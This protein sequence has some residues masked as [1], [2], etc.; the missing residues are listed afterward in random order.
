MLYAAV[1]LSAAWLSHFAM[2]SNDVFPLRW[3]ANQL[4][5]HHPETFYDG[6]FPIGYPLLLR[7]AGLTG[8]PVLAT[9]I[10]QIALAAIYARLAWGVLRATLSEEAAIIAL[11]F[12]LFLPQI[13]GNIL[14]VTPDFLAALSAIA[15]FCFLIPTNTRRNIF[16]AGICLG[17]GYLF[18][19][20]LIVLV[21]SLTLALLI[22]EKKR[23]FRAILWL[24]AGALPFVIAQ[25]MLQV[26]S[27]HGFF[28][29][30]QA[31]N[32]WRM[33]HGMDWNNPPALDGVTAFEIM[34]AN[35]QIFFTAYQNALLQEW[36]YILPT[37]VA[38][39]FLL[40]RGRSTSHRALS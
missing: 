34:R 35:S 15:A 8:N 37:L 6:F 11:P 17:A 9:M 23:R 7:L 4:S 31:F 25:G 3:Q 1:L 24:F 40:K 21:L 28:E 20:H 5:L 19:T 18:R 13:A 10:L 38:L 32:M 16:F 33:I 27:G 29:N 30:A 12:V 36:G 39:L 2:L 22:F 26:W 14:S